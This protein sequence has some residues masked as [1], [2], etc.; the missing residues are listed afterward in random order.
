VFVSPLANEGIDPFVTKDSDENPLLG[1]P[2]GVAYETWFTEIKKLTEVLCSRQ[3]SSRRAAPVLCLPEQCCEAGAHRQDARARLISHASGRIKTRVP[4]SSGC[5]LSVV[6]AA[7]RNSPLSFMC[8]R[9]FSNADTAE[10]RA[11]MKQIG[12]KTRCWM[13]E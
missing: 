11:D 1:W 3:L 4:C 13:K 5:C 6:V 7:A 10:T 2:Q 9:V 8:R 12:C